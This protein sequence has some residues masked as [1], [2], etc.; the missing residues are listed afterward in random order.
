MTRRIRMGLIGHKF[1]GKAHSHALH[2]LSFFFPLGV[3]LERAVLCG[4]EEDLAEA[5]ARYGWSAHTHSWRE[6]VADPD[7]HVICIATPGDTHCEIAVAAAEAGKHVLCEKPLA[8]NAAEARRMWEAAERARV[9]HMVNFNYRRVPA[10]NLAKQL[11]EDGRLGRLYYFRA[12]YWQDWPLDPQFPFVWRFDKN[13]A[14][15]GSMADKGSHL[16]DLARF[17]V[18]EIEEVAAA[19]E[20]FVRERP[21]AEGGRATV[22]T[23][24]AAAFIVRFRNGALGLF[25]TSRM[26]AGHK[27][28]LGFEVNGSRGSVSFDLERLNELQVYL[29]E[30]D[31]AVEGFRTVMVTQPAHR[32]ISHW[33]P[34]GHIIGWEH[35][36]IHQYYEFLRAISEDLAP[37]PNFLDGLRVQQVLDAVETAAAEKRWVR[38]GEESREGSL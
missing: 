23:D 8:L 30:D 19:T 17:L 12:T 26:S 5:A 11:I 4:V 28:A 29:R 37:S 32:Y 1:M 13:V 27:N 18:G 16:V 24:D 25:G 22:T 14:G 33:W 15:A 38:V 6:V 36:F 35:T 2:D 10:V 21:T 9:K 34:P 20:I 31:Q 7:I 3:E